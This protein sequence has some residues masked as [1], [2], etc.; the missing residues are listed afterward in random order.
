MEEDVR[1]SNEEIRRFKV[2]LERAL[3]YAKA[4]YLEDISGIQDY[5]LNAL[6]DLEKGSIEELKEREKLRD[7]LDQTSDIFKREMRFENHLERAIDLSEHGYFEDKA[8][9]ESI[10]NEALDKFHSG[11]YWEIKDDEQLQE[12]FSQAENIRNVIIPEEWDRKYEESLKPHPHFL[13]RDDVPFYLASETIQEITDRLDK[14]NGELA[15][16]LM[17]WHYEAKSR[18]FPEVQERHMVKRV[19]NGQV[20]HV[21]TKP[22]GVV[23]KFRV[24]RVESAE[25]ILRH[26]NHY[27]YREDYVQE[28]ISKG[29]NYF[30]I[31]DMCNNMFRKLTIYLTRYAASKG[32]ALNRLWD[33]YLSTVDTENPES[34][35]YYDSVYA[36]G[37]FCNCSTEDEFKEY[38]PAIMRSYREAISEI[39]MLATIIRPDL[40]LVEYASIKN[41]DDLNNS[42]LKDNYSFDDLKE[43]TS[44][45]KSRLSEYMKTWPTERKRG[46]S[47]NREQ[48]RELLEYIIEQGPIGDVE[49]RCRKSLEE[50]R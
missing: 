4:G 12:I 21:F 10:L 46:E 23:E 39:E 47:I 50:L 28:F 18:C 1:K 45:G 49:N 17:M 37:T 44:L 20:S 25:K 9:I 14:D 6:R 11:H 32:L 48:A 41:I 16:C 31:L 30:E 36:F 40:V 19:H 15:Y 33:F 2:Y 22:N 38:Q 26:P 3:E 34:H 29:D 5:L 13:K 8:K 42:K 7:I 24:P 35:M 27:G 43:L